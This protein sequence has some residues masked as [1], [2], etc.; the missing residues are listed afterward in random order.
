METVAPPRVV[1]HYQRASLTECGLVWRASP[2]VTR[3]F[4]FLPFCPSTQLM[5]S[6]PAEVIRVECINLVFIYSLWMQHGC[7]NLE[8]PL[9]FGG[10]LHQDRQS[11][12]SGDLSVTS[13][14]LWS[15]ENSLG[16]DSHLSAQIGPCF[17]ALDSCPRLP[18]SLLNGPPI[19]SCQ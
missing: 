10:V 6:P 3:C 19:C 14:L 11:V 17:S 18:C 1:S 9:H 12:R 16:G 15:W 7:T 8:V 2:R 4:D 5:A 13:S